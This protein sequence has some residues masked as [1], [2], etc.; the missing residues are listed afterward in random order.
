MKFDEMV[1]K[2]KSTK[3]S[4]NT[5]I[6]FLVIIGIVGI[7]IVIFVFKAI[8][9]GKEK[10]TIVSLD[11]N[12]RLVQSLYTTVHD[13]KSTSPYWMYDGESSS[14]ISDMTEVHKM[15]LAYLNLKGVDFLEADDCT[16]LP[17]ENDY[18]KLV[19]SDKT[20]IKREDVERSYQEVFGDKFQMSTD[21]NIKVNPNND[22]YVYNEDIDSYVLYT[23][24]SKDELFSTDYSYNYDIYKAE[25]EGDVVRVYE[26]LDVE[27]KTGS[28]VESAKYLYT[29]KM[30]DDNLYNFYSIESVK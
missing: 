1:S 19:C 22:T 26:S 17:S 6:L 3:K 23:Q 15:V 10:V 30:S 20:I 29:F 5:K 2:S 28:I 9:S 21:V 14:I 4:F 24:G 11:K 25:R 16:S 13:F 7:I 12:S 27:D 8:F 18:G